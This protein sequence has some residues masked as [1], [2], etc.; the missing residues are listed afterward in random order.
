[1]PKIDI[2]LKTPL[3]KS[4]FRSVYNYL[5]VHRHLEEHVLIS[6]QAFFDSF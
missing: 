5:Y 1:M 2:I 6:A 3:L 4:N